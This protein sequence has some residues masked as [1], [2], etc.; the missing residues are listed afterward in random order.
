MKKILEKLDLQN[1]LSKEE[2]I[3]F[4]ENIDDEHRELLFAKAR[5][6]KEQY[7]GDKVYLRGLIEFSNICKQ[8]CLYCGIRRSNTEVER[9]RLTPEE[10]IACCEIGYELGYRTFVLQSGEDA[11]FTAE[12]L[13]GLVKKIKR[14]FKDAAITLSLGERDHDTYKALFAA[15][16]DRYLLRHETASPRLYKDLH[17]T[18]DYANR[19]KCLADLK[20]IGYQV[21][22]GFMVGLPNQTTAD[23]A[24]DLLFLYNLQPHMIGIGPFISQQHTPLKDAENGSVETTLVMVAL[25]R[26]LVADSLIPATTALGSLDESGRE[27]ALLAGANV[28]MPN[29][30]PIAARQKYQ[31]YD[32]KICLGDESAKCRWCIEKRIASVG[33]SVDLSR[34]DCLR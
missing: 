10:I 17:P 31:L 23:L 9:Y 29:L 18:M 3:F 16:A 30:T 25:A 12:I 11:W 8:D 28:V 33:Y 15:G 24:E 22:A 34:G 6:R 19:R 13:S 20:S 21:G 26:L 14:R 32:N 1:S 5:S 4:L 7:Y 2:I 27:K